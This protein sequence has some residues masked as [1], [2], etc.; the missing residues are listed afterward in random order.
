[1]GKEEIRVYLFADN[2]I[3]YVESSMKSTKKA[4]RTNV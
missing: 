2:M 1:M 4:V 3:I